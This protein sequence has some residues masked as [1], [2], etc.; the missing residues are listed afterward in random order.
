VKEVCQGP[1][2]PS[3][4]AR[5][6]TRSGRCWA[7]FG[8]LDHPHRSFSLGVPGPLHNQIPA[9]DRSVDNTKPSGRRTSTRP[10]TEALLFS[11]APG[12]VSMRNFLHR[13][14]GPTATAVNGGRHRLGDGSLTMR[15]RTGVTTAAASSAPRTWVFV[16]HSIDAWYTAQ[17][18]AG[19]TMAEINAYLAP[20]MSGIA[21]DYNGNGNFDEPDRL[22]RP[23][24][25]RSRR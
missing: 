15:L 2:C 10:T 21:Y 1:V 22:H 16:N 8:P 11:E 13:A 17:I 20:S 19:K 9:P 4:S 18:S 3:W 6:K 24:P 7:S 5:A 14:I 25:V 12:A 23:L